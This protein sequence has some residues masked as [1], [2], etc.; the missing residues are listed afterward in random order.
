MTISRA[1]MR[2]QLKGNPM[3]KP[4]KKKAVGGAIGAL[5]KGDISGAL[6]GALM[7]VLPQMALKQ[8]EKRKDKRRGEGPSGPSDVTG[9]KKGGKVGRGDGACMKGRTK[10]KMV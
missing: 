1:N 3:K 8:S 10:G 7:G 6:P 9:M 5:M 4:V 2:Q